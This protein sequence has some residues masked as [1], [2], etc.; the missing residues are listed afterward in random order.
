MLLFL[1][2]SLVA[3]CKLSKEDATQLVEATFRA[4]DKVLCSWSAPAMSSEGD[5]PTANKVFSFIAP[6]HAANE[7]IWALTKAKVLHEG[8]CLQMEA[9]NADRLSFCTKTAYSV[10]TGATVNSDLLK[11]ECGTRKFKA[12]TA[13]STNGNKAKVRYV[14]TVS[15]DDPLI[16]K[17]SACTLDVP[18]AGSAELAMSFTRDDDG[19]WSPAQ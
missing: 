15:L 6:N 8:E 12:F 1:C 5:S 4:N 10:G 2:F 3:C 9:F 16:A 7:C 18:E 14:R 11:F 13:V 17:L 19:Q